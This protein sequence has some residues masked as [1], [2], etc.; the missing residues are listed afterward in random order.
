MPDFKAHLFVCTNSRAPGAKRESCGHKGSEALRAQVKEMC[1]ARGL[2][3]VRIN[4]AGCL[5]QCEQGIAAVLY[6]QG[7]WHLNL[8]AEDAETL[9]AA[10]EKA[11]KGE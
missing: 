7:E 6:P 4:S 2:K 1:K 8:K 3:G 5:D 10:V 11:V 9:V